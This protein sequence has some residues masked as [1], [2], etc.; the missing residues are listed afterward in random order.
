MKKSLFSLLILSTLSLSTQAI[1]RHVT[2][3]AKDITIQGRVVKKDAPTCQVQPVG[4]VKLPNAEIDAFS[5]TPFAYFSINFTDCDKLK[6][7]K[8]VKVV[9]KPQ[10]DSYLTNTHKGPD[11]T[12]A[13]VALLD[14]SKNE[15]IPLNG[16]QNERTFSS[17]YLSDYS[18]GASIMF[19]LKYEGPGGSDKVTE[20]VFS[21]TLSFDAY[22]TDDIVEVSDGGESMQSNADEGFPAAVL[23]SGAGFE[24][25]RFDDE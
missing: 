4:T 19:S 16:N 25:V 20:G 8:K 12:N 11:A 24:N 18:I 15:P 3:D 6:G 21:S 2:L 14:Y 13:R 5:N 9:F 17:D 23:L 22:V 10:A 7:N 1:A